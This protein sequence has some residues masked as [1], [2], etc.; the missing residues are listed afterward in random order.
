MRPYSFLNTVVLINGREITH[1]AEGD[2]VIN[3]EHLTDLASHKIGADGHMMM[4][5]SAD[6]S[7]EF[8]IK[9]QQ[10][11]P[12]NKYLLGLADIVQAGT[13]VFVP[14]LVMFQDIYRND[15]GTGVNGYIKKKANITRGMQA[16]N[17]EWV[18]VVE[19][20][21]MLLGDPSLGAAFLG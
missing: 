15:L 13:N 16:N 20:L 5:I 8:T 21:D 1:W 2:D 14:V 11:S 6:R 7:G 3:I 17:T 9:L 19:S 4:S 18:V 10:T 12:S